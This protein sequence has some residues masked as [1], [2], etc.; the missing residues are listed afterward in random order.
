M[1]SKHN[2]ELEDKIIEQIN[3]L[4]ITTRKKYLIMNK[5]TINV[6]DN[7]TTTGKYYEIRHGQDN[8]VPL[9][10]YH[11]R[12]HIRGKSTIG[13]FS[14]EN[15]SKFLCFDL[16]FKD[17]QKLKWVYYLLVDSLNE[18]GINDNHIHT[19]TSGNKGMHV[20]I[21]IEDGTNLSNLI[22]LFNS[23][24]NTIK[25]KLSND[26]K[27]N[28]YSSNEHYGEFDFG[29][30]EM[31]CT[32]TQGV[33]IELGRN[34]FNPDFSTNKCLFLDNETLESHD[35][36]YILTIDPINKDEFTYI[37]EELKDEVYIN[38]DVTLIKES[39]TEPSYMKIN[40][41]ES[42]TIDYI[43]NLLING[44]Y[45]EGTRHNSCLKIAKYFRYMGMSE[46]ECVV[47]LQD[48]MSKQDKK[49][50]SSTIEYA[51]SECERISK[52][53]YEKEYSLFGHVEN[54]KIYK[55]EIAKIVEVTSKYDKL[56]LYS[57][58]IHSKRYALKN[59][60]FY[61]TYDQIRELSGIGIDGA[62]SSIE[63]LEEYGVL[64]VVSR[65][66]K[67]EF[68]YK[69]KPNKYKLLLDVE[70]N[71]D[72]IILEIDNTS[73]SIN[74]NELYLKSITSIFTNKDLKKVLP[75]TQYREMS[76][77]RKLIAI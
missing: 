70:L 17:K 39:I 26:I 74:C 19:A 15:I 21:F 77:Y 57:M 46:E 44:L 14:G 5:T 50:Y 43:K 61:M 48:W 30:I 73:E 68:G 47:N 53:V 28:S 40:K 38:N 60:V 33:K 36:E 6:D 24:M 29:Q 65:N 35:I 71:E 18:L 9:N 27:F 58:L 31:R 3:K 25:G 1:M 62:L 75:D 69:R 8:F 32:S 63:R 11:I 37:I 49:Y 23:T 56:L 7:K 54:I 16:D 76:K 10:D 41:D 12:N 55:S 13:V 67:S 72:E 59:G 64:E 22:L 52:I 66:V 20:N 45:M 51:L 42:E 34:F 2:V 4:Y